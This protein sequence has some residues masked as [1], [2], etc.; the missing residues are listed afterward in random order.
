MKRERERKEK[1]TTLADEVKWLSVN[2]S[3]YYSLILSLSLSLS[4]HK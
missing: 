2:M 1:K 3:S 4:L